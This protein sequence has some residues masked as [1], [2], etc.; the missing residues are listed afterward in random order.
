MGMMAQ[1]CAECRNYFVANS[2]DLHY[3][4]Y[5]IESGVLSPLSFIQNG[6]YYRIS[7]S[8]LNDGVYQHGVDDLNLQDES[9]Y[10]TIWAMR[11]PKD[12]IELVNDIESWSE[13]HASAIDSPYSSESFGG[14]S[15]TKENVDNKPLS[16]QIHFAPRLNMY[17]RLVV[18][19]P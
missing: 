18:G 7:G 2:A 6:Q 13:S 19:R 11:V 15:Y 9:F 4:L 14:Y 1:V 8:V 5:T 16:W 17:K 3:Q 10:G 12:F